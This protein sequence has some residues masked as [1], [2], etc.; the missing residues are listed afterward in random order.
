VLDS[1]AN[2]EGGVRVLVHTRND[3]L[4]TVKPETRLP[5]NFGRFCGL[6]EGLFAKG[7][8]PEDVRLL[9]LEHGRTLASALEGLEGEVVAFDLGGEAVELPGWLASR[10]DLVAV[11]GAFP[12]GPFRSPVGSLCARVVSLHE[13][14]LMAWTAASEL[15][16]AYRLV[17]RPPAAPFAGPAPAVPP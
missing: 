7:A 13:K 1:V 5:R 6:M 17:H 12:H 3:D 8:V 11:I 14:P 9:T 2:Q 15:L 16:V 4:I 10:R